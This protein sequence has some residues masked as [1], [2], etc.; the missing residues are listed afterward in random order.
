MLAERN[1]LLLAKVAVDP[2][3]AIDRRFHSPFIQL[4]LS[5]LDCLQ[6]PPI[7]L[8]V[9]TVTGSFVSA[10]PCGGQFEA[11]YFQRSRQQI[12]LVS[13]ARRYASLR[14]ALK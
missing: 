1:C 4:L 7:V 11:L 8:H 10:R 2:R 14:K 13:K 6:P 3:A 12:D 9:R 5:G